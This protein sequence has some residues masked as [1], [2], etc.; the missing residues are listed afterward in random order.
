[1]LLFYFLRADFEITLKS[2]VDI[3]KD[4]GKIVIRI[5]QQLKENKNTK[6]YMNSQC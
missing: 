2:N 4:D 6:V 3:T 1:V 5:G